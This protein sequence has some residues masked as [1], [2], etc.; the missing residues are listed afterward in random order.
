MGNVKSLVKAGSGWLRAQQRWGYSYV[1][2][3]CWCGDIRGSLSLIQF[4]RRPKSW[5]KISICKKIAWKFSFNC[6]VSFGQTLWIKLNRDNGKYFIRRGNR[7]YLK[8]W[9]TS[10]IPRNAQIKI[11][12]W[13]GCYAALFVLFILEIEVFLCTL[14]WYDIHYIV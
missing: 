4:S 8:T 14:G 2:S 9:T 7:K 3:V 1:R 5:S 13:G 10:H 11:F 6:I 12:C